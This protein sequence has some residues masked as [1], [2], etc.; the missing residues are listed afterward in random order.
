MNKILKNHLELIKYL[1]RE[2]KVK[3]TPKQVILFLSNIA[4]NYCKVMLREYK[5]LFMFFDKDY[6]KQK[7]NYKQYQQYQKD[8]RNAYR[9]IQYMIKMGEDR[10]TRK[11]IR[12]DFEKYGVIN[13]EVEK[14]IL[15]DIYKVED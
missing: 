2:S 9:V 4:K 15:K 1:L 13:K 11:N 7:H 8:L 10:T 6:K 12:R 14:K 3:R 5:N